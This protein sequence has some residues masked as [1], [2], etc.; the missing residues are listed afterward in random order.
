MSSKICR[1]VAISVS[2]VSMWL[3]KWNKLVVHLFA[4]KFDALVK[5][6]N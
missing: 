1:G 5:S 6:Q 4:V 2:I 3:K